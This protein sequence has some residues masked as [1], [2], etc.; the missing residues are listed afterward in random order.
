M[1]TAPPPHRKVGAKTK[2]TQTILFIYLD[3]LRE[4]RSWTPQGTMAMR[5]C[6]NR[7]NDLVHGGRWWWWWWSR[8]VIDDKEEIREDRKTCNQKKV[9]ANLQA[10]HLYWNPRDWILKLS[11]TKTE[12]VAIYGS[13]P[14]FRLNMQLSH[15]GACHSILT[16]TVPSATPFQF[17]S[18]FI[19]SLWWTILRKSIA[20]ENSD[21]KE[22]SNSVSALYGL[23]FLKDRKRSVFQR[24]SAGNSLKTQHNKFK[25][26]NCNTN[27]VS[28]FSRMKKT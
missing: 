23:S 18:T 16:V 21:F 7:S 25:M 22:R 27:R 19:L 2:N 12:F 26:E 1:G 13:L 24:Q 6:R 28:L 3:T 8:K 5:R 9:S 15:R 10:R 11:K 17:C 14:V 20:N 4:K